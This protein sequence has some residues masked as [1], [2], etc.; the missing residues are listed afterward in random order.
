MSLFD[1]EDDDNVD[2]VAELTGPGKKFDKTKF[3]SDAELL[4]ALA[5]SNYHG[6]R[7]IDH[8][9]K[10]FDELREEYLNV[11]AEN[12][13]KAKFEEFFKNQ[14]KNDDDDSDDNNQRQLNTQPAFDPSKIDEI[15]EAKLAE[16]EAR[17]R[18]QDNMNEVEKRLR[19]RLGDSAKRVLKDKMNSL[20][21][22][23]EDIK[24]LAKKSPEAVINA[25]GLNQTTEPYGTPPR[26]SLRSDSFAPQADIRDAVYYEKM[27]MEQP[28]LYFSEK[29]SVQRLKDMDDPAFMTRYKQRQAQS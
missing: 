29:I 1:Q 2:F 9:N 4:K 8:K 6:D 10:E 26:S 27:R 25:L 23:E 17:K 28:K 22:S 20:G 5:K 16:K 18:E 7:F 19:D 24:F 11:S 14:R 15:L 13:A 21:F 12:K 3:S